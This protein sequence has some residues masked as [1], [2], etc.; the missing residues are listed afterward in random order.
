MM[1]ELSVLDRTGDTKIIWDSA[2]DA[3]VDAARAAF[4]DLKKRGYA[5][6]SVTKKGDKG[7]LMK[8]FDP[9]AEKII[10]A[11]ALQGG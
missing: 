3:E 1:G 7:E 10:M 2:Q 4:D 6:F 9:D 8:K 5:A 11:P